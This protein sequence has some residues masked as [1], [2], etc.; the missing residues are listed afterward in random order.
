M[1]KIIELENKNSFESASEWDTE[2]WID[3]K[4]GINERQDML[5][6]LNIVSLLCSIIA[7]EKSRSINEEAILFSIA[8]LLGGNPT[9]QKKF[10]QYI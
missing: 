9:S 6:D 1:R 2:D 8:V 5:T 4:H 3:F 10:F 7:K